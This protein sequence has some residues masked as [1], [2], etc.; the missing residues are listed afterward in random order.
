[1]AGYETLKAWEA[2]H[3]LARAVCD[4]ARA[5]P[6]DE[7]FELT[8][9]LRRA[10]LSAPTNLVEGRARYGSREYLR[11]VRIAAGSLAEVD[12]LLLFAQESG[13][14]T[15]EEFEQLRGLRR[16]ASTLVHRLAMALD[17]QSQ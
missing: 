14:L 15:A 7:R 12:Y 9:Q 2:T 5:F 4:A 16:R 17:H 10:A 11:H 8:S 13:Y 3:V 1:M 6:R